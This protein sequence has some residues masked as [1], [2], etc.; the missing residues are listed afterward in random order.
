MTISAPFLDRFYWNISIGIKVDTGQTPAVIFTFCKKMQKRDV[1]F[2]IF[3][4]IWDARQAAKENKFTFSVTMNVKDKT[5]FSTFGMRS[6]ICSAVNLPQLIFFTLTDAHSVQ[7]HS[8]VLPV[9]QPVISLPISRADISGAHSASGSSSSTALSLRLWL[10]SVFKKI[11]LNWSL[12]SQQGSLIKPFSFFQLEWRERHSCLR[13]CLFY[14][15][16]VRSCWV[17]KLHLFAPSPLL[18]NQ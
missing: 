12:V 6:L 10:R 5:S 3:K 13:F 7:Q 15:S 16:S 1:L 9:A 8:Y 4:Q 2:Q 18:P 17:D 11:C 14:N